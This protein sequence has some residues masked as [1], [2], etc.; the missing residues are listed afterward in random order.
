MTSPRK[1]SGWGEFSGSG[2]PPGRRMFRTKAWR[3]RLRGC[4]SKAWRLRLRGCSSK[5]WRLRLP[6][7]D[8]Y[9]L[10]GMT[11]ILTYRR[12]DPTT[13]VYMSSFLTI[14]LFF[15]FRRFWSIRNVDV[16]LL[17]ALAPGLSMVHAGYRR[18][19]PQYDAELQQ[20]IEPTE[21][22]LIDASRIGHAGYL[23]L[24]AVE[25]LILG[26]LLLD[27]LMDRR[28]LLDPNLTTGGLYFI[29]LS[30][31]L[32][33]MA[34]VVAATPAVQR[35]AGPPLGPGYALIDRLPAIPTRQSSAAAAA[36]VNRNEPMI[37]W[38]NAPMTGTRIW[39]AKTI[40]IA[41]QSVILIG[42]VLIG[43]RHFGNTQAGAGCAM[44]YLLLPYT[45]QM[46]GRVDHVLP[47]AAMV[48]AVF[49]Y[50]RPMVSGLAIGMAAG[51]VYY[52][53][54]LLPLWFG[55][56]W[57]RGVRPFAIG[58]AAALAIMTALLFLGDGGGL[59]ESF[60][61]RVR[62]MYGLM[63]NA[64][65]QGI[66]STGWDPVWRVPV[67]VGFVILSFFL[68]VWPSQ[69]DLGV[70]ISSSAAVMLAT[71]FWHGAG[72]GLYMAWFLPLTLLAIYR[73]NLRDRLA[74]RV[75]RPA[76]VRI[77]PPATPTELATAT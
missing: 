17:I 51:L 55:F 60:A 3:L 16:V 28:P 23:W 26:R 70:L 2:V 50:H 71:Q 69:K 61:G 56:Y 1:R 11:E 25:S 31:F 24:F 54:F 21:Q 15:V 64:D 20:V 30:L 41:S 5:A 35:A 74:T 58:V 43:S 75:V 8:S 67:I 48:L 10:I 18:A 39:A 36:T 62:Q 52:P 13:W 33:M 6:E 42:M 49:F 63:F 72:G 9:P 40:A 7:I 59:A 4:S 27:P 38:A 32:F 66:W 65:P 46:T 68:A 73:P 37:D 12:P 53:L 34:N 45:A 14:G 57:K 76:A 29:G 77:R 22:T 47:A 44:L 19:E